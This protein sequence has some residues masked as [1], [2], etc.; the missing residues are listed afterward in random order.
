MPVDT[1]V[2]RQEVA[3]QF[4][5]RVGRIG[6]ERHFQ[7]IRLADVPDIGGILDRYRHVAD[8]LLR[9]Q[10]RACTI[11]FVQ[12][13]AHI[14]EVEAGERT[15]K[16]DRH[17]VLDRCG[18]QTRRRQHAG[19]ARDQH[20]ADAEFGGKRG[21]MDRPGATERHQRETTR[22]EAAADRDQPNALDHLRVHHA[23]D[24]E[25]RVFDRQA[26]RSRDALLDRGAGQRWIERQRSRRRNTPGSSQPSTT[27]ASVTVASSPPRP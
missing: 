14:G 3:I 13:A 15:R 21:R 17:L 1:I 18:E 12:H 19:M 20:V 4:A 24:A 23:M 11:Q 10:P 8:A 6:V 26:E 16:G 9:H 27:D 25:R 22:I 2:Q 7:M 5:Q